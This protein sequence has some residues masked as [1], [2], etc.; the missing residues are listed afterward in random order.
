MFERVL[1]LVILIA[2]LRYS[3]TDFTYCNKANVTIQ[4]NFNYSDLSLIRNV[5]NPFVLYSSI[6]VTNIQVKLINNFIFANY[7]AIEINLS[8]NEIEFMS[9]NSFSQIVYLEKLKLSGNRIK[10]ID[11][12][13]DSLDATI[14]ELDLSLNRIQKMNKKFTIIFQSLDKLK[15]NNNNQ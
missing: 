6:R 5:Y 14:H 10:S 7:C 12:L 4:Q 2:I 13:I 8:N 15:L 11:G 9:A 1:K 3:Q